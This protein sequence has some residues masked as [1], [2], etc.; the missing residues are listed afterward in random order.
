MGVARK[1]TKL[2]RDQVVLLRKGGTSW[3]KISKITGIPRGTCR[4]IWEAD[5][6]LGEEAEPV[7]PSEDEVEEAFVLKHVPNP[8]LMLIAF[9]GRE[10]FA[11]CVKRAEERRSVN[12]KLL[13]KRVEDD[14]YRIV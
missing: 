6:I 13:V 8:R 5:G 1:W 12:S 11:R 9:P 4:G 14:L 7:T 10:G 3:P 2:D